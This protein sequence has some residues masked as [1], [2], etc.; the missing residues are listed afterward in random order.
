MLGAPVDPDP[1]WN[2]ALAK[3]A[4][5]L[6]GC[7]GSSGLFLEDREDLRIELDGGTTCESVRSR[8]LGLSA[9]AGL[10]RPRLVYL[11][12]AEP[13]DASHLARAARSGGV[14][15]RRG[16]WR[17]P[18]P[19]RDPFS[20]EPLEMLERALSESLRAGGAR[21]A[22]VTGRIV[23]F[24][25]HARF[26][27]PTACVRADRREGCRLRIEVRAGANGRGSI[28]VGERALRPG[29]HERIEELAREVAER[30]IV[31][32]EAKRPPAGE[33]PVVFAPGVGGVLLHEL[34]GHALEGD[35]ILRS[36]SALASH[37]G[38]IAS[39][40]VTVADDPRRGRAPWRIDDEGEEARSVPLVQSGRVVGAVHDSRSARLSGAA[41]TG[42][43]RRATYQEDVKPRLGCTFLAP[44][45]LAPEEVLEGMS[46][47]IYVRRMEAASADPALGSA[48]FRVTDA[49]RIHHGH[50]DAPLGPMLL[51]VFTMQALASLDRIASDLSFD[52]CIGS[53]VRDGQALATSVGAPT[54]RIGLTKVVC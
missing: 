13:D 26:A 23:A 14:V 3:A 15:A 21:V 44:G 20:T 47:G 24:R 49:D 45:R 19:C 36:A 1:L 10:D 54:F 25:Q 35:T 53:C 5:V 51:W 39:R 41:P 50:L 11:G 28:A 52:T 38:P 31:R 7:G 8:I 42:H 16:R 2:E 40:E 29:R 27:R 33:T 32:L 17:A 18:S 34:V 4:Q 48:M 22:R 9:T 6:A 46:S 37:D 30:A 12:D 43:G